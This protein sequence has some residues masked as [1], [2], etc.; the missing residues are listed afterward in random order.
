MQISVL[1]EEMND[2]IIVSDGCELEEIRFGMRLGTVCHPR[3][4]QRS[5]ALWQSWRPSDAALEGQALRKGKFR[6]A[7][8]YPPS[9]WLCFY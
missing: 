5:R 6:L 1:G 4:G 7:L 9:C 3:G 8:S 2:A